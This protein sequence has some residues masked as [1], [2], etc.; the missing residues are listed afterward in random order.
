M[1]VAAF[2]ASGEVYHT[3]DPCVGHRLPSQ[4]KAFVWLLYAAAIRDSVQSEESFRILLPVPPGGR[5][6]SKANSRSHPPLKRA[7]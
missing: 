2:V 1:R 6:R 3:E 4:V 5:S 7:P